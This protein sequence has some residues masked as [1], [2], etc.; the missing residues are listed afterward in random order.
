MNVHFDRIAAD[1]LI[2]PVQALLELRPRQHGAGPLQ[3]RLE[4]GIENSCADSGD[5]LAGPRS[6]ACVRRIEAQVAVLDRAGSRQARPG[7]ARRS[8]E[9]ARMR[10]I[11]SS[12]SKGLTM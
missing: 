11:T 6:T 5:G 2:P 1:G 3:Q 8:T 10:A 7:A 9:A 12:R 4:N